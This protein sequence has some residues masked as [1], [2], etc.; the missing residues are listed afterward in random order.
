MGQRTDTYAAGKVVMQMKDHI[1][2]HQEAYLAGLA[3]IGIGS[4][5]TMGFF[6]FAGR[7]KIDV[8]LAVTNY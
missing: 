8:T 1:E 2:D 4:L 6:S 5:L 3:G 7:P